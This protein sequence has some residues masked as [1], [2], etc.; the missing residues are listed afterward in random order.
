[1]KFRNIIILLLSGIFI[2]SACD[3]VEPPYIRETVNTGDKRKILLEDFTGHQC[4][5]CPSAAEKAH[6]LNEQYEDRIIV[7]GIHS[8][9][10]AE[11]LGNTYS[12][13]YTTDSGDELYEYFGVAANPT[14]VINRTEYNGSILQTD[15]VSSWGSA[16][17]EALAKDLV[18][19]IEI[20]PVFDATTSTLETTLLIDFE[21]DY[22]NPVKVCA[23]ITES[24]I[25]SPQKNN[26]EEIGPD[27][28]LDYEHNHVLRGAINGTWG[29]DLTGGDGLNYDFTLPSYV[30]NE[31]WVPENCNIVAFIYD[32]V[33]KEVLQ[34]EESP[35][36]LQ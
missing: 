23:Y 21:S 3:K 7:I 11:P 34:A 30:L 22:D 32:D 12:A 5:N 1:M 19:E 9:F 24:G 16:V 10:F 13:D 8:G 4:V 15:F 28:I 36:I 26:N 2:W 18:A 31:N 27:E 14:G 35:V 6:E 33:S 29:E 20:Q 25:I 17:G